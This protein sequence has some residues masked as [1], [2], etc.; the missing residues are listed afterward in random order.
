MASGAVAGPGW[1]LAHGGTTIAEVRDIS[2]PVATADTDDVTNQSSTG[3]YKEKITTLLDGGDVTFD[4][5][6]VPGNA[7]QIALLTALQNR[8]IETF[9][10]TPPGGGGSFA[11]E[12]RVSKWGLDKAPVAKAA[13]LAITLAVTGPITVT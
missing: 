10:L 11:F 2:G 3:F 9:T 8:G 1:V 12:A 6:Y 4:C 7:S 13:T 5:N